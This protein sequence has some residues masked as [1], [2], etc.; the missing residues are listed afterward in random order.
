MN[1]ITL[2]DV[3]HKSF[4]VVWDFKT[5]PVWQKEH[6][7][8]T[9]KIIYEW[10]TAFIKAFL[11]W[12]DQEREIISFFP[13]ISPQIYIS[14]NNDTYNYMI[15]E[16]LNLNYVSL[17]FRSMNMND[18]M[19]MHQLYRRN[20]EKHAQWKDFNVPEQ[21]HTWAIDKVS[22]WIDNTYIS[23]EEIP[24]HEREKI[25]RAFIEYEETAVI[26]KEL[27]FWVWWPPHLWR[28]KEKNDLRMIDWWH[29]KYMRKW[30]EVLWIFWA[31]ILMRIH[32]YD[33][34]AYP[35]WK[36]ECKNFIEKYNIPDTILFQKLIWTLFADYGNLMVK[37]KLNRKNIEDEWYNPDKNA[38]K[39][40]ERTYQLIKDLWY[41]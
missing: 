36:N 18:I 7:S 2:K 5:W 15:L 12:Y 6:T 25:K 4:N 33:K 11:P 8:I 31:K 28:N 21:I 38:T 24:S 3:I 17:D 37:N 1:L 27:S 10:K 29:M 30:S 35:E 19:G 40:R 14:E 23:E 22:E 9:A 41:I 34:N 26:E 13:S 32:T 20:F 39:W 16:D